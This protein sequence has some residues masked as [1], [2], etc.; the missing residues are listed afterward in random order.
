MSHFR[1]KT[2][3]SVT[4]LA[5]LALAGPA[6]TAQA[7]VKTIDYPGLKTPVGQS[8]T[9]TLPLS[10]FT[11]T[12]EKPGAAEKPI[13]DWRR[14]SFALKFD[15]P[16][17]DWTSSLQLTLSA[18]PVG[19]APR[20]AEIYVQ[21]NDAAPLKVSTQ[22]RGFDARL[23]LDPAHVRPR[24]NVLTI[25]YKT[26]NTAECLQETD[27]AWALNLTTSRLTL[28]SR[29]KSRPLIISDIE[30]E[31][32][33]PLTA[34][35][36]VS[37]VSFG[38]SATQIQSLLAQAVGL[39]MQETPNFSTR[40]AKGQIKDQ[41][42]FIAGRRDQISGFVKNVYMMSVSG[43]VLT[44]DE[45]RPLRVILTG[46]TDKEVLNLVQAFAQNHLPE[47]RRTWISPGELKV[48]PLLSSGTSLSEGRTKLAELGPTAFGPGWSPKDL[49]LRFDVKD[50]LASKGD[51]LLRL[52]TPQAM[53]GA[54][55][56]LT[57]SLNG[58]ALGQTRLDKTQ[59]SVTF[60]I[61][62]GSLQGQNNIIKM[63]ANLEPDIRVE[64]RS[65]ALIGCK[66]QSYTTNGLFIEDG[67]RLTLKQE[68][69]TP[70]SDLSHLTATGAPFSDSDGK[71]T[72]FVLPKNNTGYQAALGMLAKFAK[73]S[74]SSWSG[75]VFSRESENIET[76]AK[77]RN[78]FFILPSQ[79]LPQKVKS[80][81]P[82]SLQSALRGK[83]E[84][85][86]NL[87]TASAE[88]YASNQAR[89]LTQNFAAKT[90]QRNRVTNGG[91][92]ALYA[93]PYQFDKMV[94]VI[95]N[96]PGD[97]FQ[98]ALETLSD[99]AHWNKI[100]GQVARW[101]EKSVLMTELSSP[102]P[103][104]KRTKT[105]SV[106]S[107]FS[108]PKLH[109]PELNWPDVSWPEID[110]SATLFTLPE[111]HLPEVNLPN[112]KDKLF[113]WK[114][115]SGSLTDSGDTTESDIAFRDTG[116]RGEAP[117][118]K[119][120]T[121]LEN[122]ALLENK[123]PSESKTMTKSVSPV[124]LTE[125]QSTVKSTVSNFELDTRVSNLKNQIKSAQLDGRRALKRA[126]LPGRSI[127]KW[128]LQQLSAAVFLLLLTFGV[129]VVF[130]GF[131]KP[132][133]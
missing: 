22:G 69:E 13:L 132:R 7:D 28:R 85:G 18:D 48:Q 125:L 40:P 10:A 38:E 56:A 57:L 6:V 42:E 73:T 41:V 107:G 67:S 99:P 90:I 103:E 39:R 122:K 82:K 26:P 115:E 33:N 123:A 2:L 126:S 100:E 74:G 64:N 119:E 96:V 65:G 25:F 88:R 8:E 62:Q 17:T 1:Q 127:G 59:K 91:V 128:S 50:P 35:Q 104:F 61:P 79:E 112:L 110:F 133:A 29:A 36:N 114:T 11:G 101:N 71:N 78:I 89:S 23:S 116:L 47:T 102:L 120:T 49:S 20:D 121:F 111:I 130:L 45:G 86:E 76:L 44:L 68:G 55:N 52:K 31:L 58:H 19:N 37:L 92:A 12:S 34:P 97:S 60:S 109:W 93:S 24:E 5:L 80:N 118:S 9:R 53:L 15:I 4:A 124:S 66:A 113:F 131:S 87:L 51:I 30:A 105:L 54:Q 63:S 81:A 106:S 95:S 32:S 77:D 108:L 46:D 43:P 129:L 27:G 117:L 14:P 3:L 94:G 98:Q 21:F 70:L 84:D 75:A 72:L 83:A 16:D